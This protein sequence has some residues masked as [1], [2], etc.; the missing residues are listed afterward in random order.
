MAYTDF[1]AAIDLGTSHIVGM[2]GTKNSSGAISIIAYEVENSDS[3]IRRGCVYN[4]KEAAAKIR[5]LILKLENKLGGS[6]IG[7]IYVGVGGQSLRTVDHVVSKLLPGGLVTEEALKDLDKE[8]KQFHPDMGYIFS[9]EGPTYFVDNRLV[10]D[11]LGVS[12]NR[13]EARYRLV[14][15][16]PSIHSSIMNNFEEVIKAQIAGIIVSPTALA[17]LILTNVEKEQGCALVDFGAGVTSVAIYKQ[18]Q[19]V[20]MSVIPLGSNLITKDIMSLNV[21]E[22]EAERLKRTYGDAIWNKDN[23]HVKVTIDLKDG[24]HSMEV[25]QSEINIIVEARAREIV[26]NIYQRLV[27]AEMNTE[28]GFS[29]VLA[30]S[31]AALKNFRELIMERFK[32]D[33]RYASVRKDKIEGG[34]MIA[35]NPDYTTAAALLL[36]ANENCAYVY[37][38]TEKKPVA[39]PVVNTKPEKIEPKQVEKP[40]FE[41]E[42]VKV[43]EKKEEEKPYEPERVQ[44]SQKP[45]TPPTGGN[46]HG[47]GN[48][49]KKG[50]G[51]F[52]KWGKK[53]IDFGDNMFNEE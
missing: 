53:V 52:G 50:G 4:I 26:E 37:K 11:P 15:G 27:D 49:N 42:P 29:I 7:K 28:P 1:I 9:I 32:M 6:R 18:G 35:C 34:E 13:L 39:E 14:V 16:R 23:D 30:G 46:T 8:C 5:R 10:D 20:S 40:I 48:V 33:V 12:G 47:T 21:S 51:L 2:V 22:K 41:P 17:E 43:E 36:R 24:Q 3:S 25:K 31:G 38:E 19:L 45:I 44:E